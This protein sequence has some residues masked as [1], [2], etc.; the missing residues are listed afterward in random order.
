[1][2]AN[3]PEPTSDDE[4]HYA[5]QDQIGMFVRQRAG[6]NCQDEGSETSGGLLQHSFDVR[7]ERCFTDRSAD[8]NLS[9]LAIR[10]DEVG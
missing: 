8:H 7:D 4:H 9:D 10:G 5:D 3:I 6:P 1:M 2:H